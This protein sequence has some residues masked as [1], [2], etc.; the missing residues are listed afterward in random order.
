MY[1]AVARTKGSEDPW[2]P[3]TWG[4]MNY[5]A[6]YQQL[7]GMVNEMARH[8]PLIEYKIIEESDE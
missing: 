8:F 2:Q 5:L 3:V 1:K 4:S 6:E 7:Q